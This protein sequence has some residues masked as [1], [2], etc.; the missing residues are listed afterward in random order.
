MCFSPSAL[1][2]R[3]PRGGQRGESRRL[4]LVT[5]DGVRVAARLATARGTAPG[6]VVLPDVRG[7]HPYYELLAEELADAGVNALA[8]DFYGRTAGAEYR[9]EHFDHAP[10]RAAVTDAGL[11][12]DV[13]AAL[14]EL[15]GAGVARSFVLGFCFGGRGAFLQASEPDVAGAIGFYGW[16]TREEDGRSPLSEARDAL[17]RAPVLALYGGADEKITE[18]DAVAYDDA[19]AAAGVA[20]ETVVYPGAPHSFFDRAMEEHAD[21]C[22]DA[23]RRVLAFMD[24]PPS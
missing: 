7:L 8:I 23:W 1:P 5:E 2:P 22:A 12:S 9:D 11:K 13:R 18:A 17:V 19:L 6:V 20:H 16:P 3:A 24:S 21:A 4:T 15:A 10:H 14:A